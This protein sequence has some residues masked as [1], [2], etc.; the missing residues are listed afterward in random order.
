MDPNNWDWDNPGDV[1]VAGEPG[2]ILRLRLSFAE[3]EALFQAARDQGLLTAEF[4]KA[5][6]LMTIQFKAP[7]TISPGASP[8]QARKLT[9]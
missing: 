2:T 8:S 1:H 4:I 5:I 3:Y 9:G 7:T 6:A